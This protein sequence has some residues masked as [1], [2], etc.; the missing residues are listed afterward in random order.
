MKKAI[1]LFDYTGIMAKPW[2]DAGYL[3]YCFD[4]QHKEGV[5]RFGNI[6]QVGMWLDDDLSKIEN[7]TGKDISFIFG[8]PECTDLAVSGAAHFEKKRN[9]NP[10]FQNDAMKLV[11][12]VD[13]IGD[14]FDCPW[15][16][17]NPISV[18]STLWRKPNYIFHPYEYGGY[19]LFDDYHPLYPDYIKPQDAYPKKTCIW[20][21]N[22]FIMPEKKPVPILTGYSDQHKKLGGK[23]LKTKNIR[24][25]TPRGFA[26]AVFEANNKL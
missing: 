11:R 9:K 26:K 4:A 12:L 18:I 6:I 2:A 23:S 24:S 5:H 14:H 7:I 17:E 8:F 19:L 16:L 22:G 25:A 20:S 10:N 3:C 15:A 21:G 1:F 13:A